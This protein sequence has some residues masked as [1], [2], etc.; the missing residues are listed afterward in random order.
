MK[1]AK[2]KLLVLE[3]APD[4]KKRFAGGPT[5]IARKTMEWS[6]WF[7]T[8]GYQL[9]FFNT[10]IFDRDDKSQGK[11]TY[12]NLKNMFLMRR[13]FIHRMKG[14][15]V[16]D[17]I[18]LHS[19]K[20]VALLKDLLIAEELAWRFNVKVV[21]HIHY[22]TVDEVLPASVFLSRLVL[23]LMRYGRCCFILLSV[24]DEVDFEAR[25]IPFE[26]MCVIPNFHLTERSGKRRKPCNLDVSIRLI[27]IGSLDRRKGVLDLI[28]ALNGISHLDFT[29]NVAGSFIDDT[30][31]K[32][33]YK[34]IND[35]KLDNNIKFLGYVTGNEKEELMRSSD[36]LI[37]PSYGEGMPVVLLEAFS[38][39]LAIITTNVGAIP[40]VIEHG[41]NGLLHQPGDVASLSLYI[42]KL[43]DDP[44]YLRKIQNYS[45]EAAEKYSPEKYRDNLILAFN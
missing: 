23:W 37:L 33:A 6:D 14:T 10:I 18:H 8:K 44:N 24:K 28:E 16:P 39:G 19:S 20:G 35:Y 15:K 25:G 30:T 42:K 41:K 38:H 45:L 12:G 40:E 13:H 11:L 22:S 31:Q 26:R 1:L 34:K 43:I 27:F 2:N 9:E 4:P 21:F 17:I 29:L 32:E 3:A 36:I 5:A 7:E